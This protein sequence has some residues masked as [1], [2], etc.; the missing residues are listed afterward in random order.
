MDVVIKSD[1][2]GGFRNLAKPNPR[3]MEILISGELTYADPIN[4][5]ELVRV[6]RSELHNS[7][8]RK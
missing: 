8:R 1:S 7:Y 2:W 3:T 6:Q 4:I 5:S